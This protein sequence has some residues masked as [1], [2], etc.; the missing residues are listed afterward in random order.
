MPMTDDSY[1]RSGTEDVLYIPRTKEIRCEIPEREW[2]HLKKLIRSVQHSGTAF[3][4][5]G[6]CLVGVAASS[7]FANLT[8]SSLSDG[9]RTICWAIFGSA[10]AVAAVTFASS[11]LRKNERAAS[12]RR[13]A[14][15]VEHIENAWTMSQDE[16]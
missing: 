2:H 16:P 8:I 5:A 11:W 12:I 4:N 1:F 14:E 7:L 3:A 10:L 9:T 6:F 13:V 15:Y